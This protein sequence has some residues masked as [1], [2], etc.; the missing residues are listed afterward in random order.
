[1]GRWRG[2]LW[3]RGGLGVGRRV[4]GGWVMYHAERE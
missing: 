3:I 4:D 1:M 2:G